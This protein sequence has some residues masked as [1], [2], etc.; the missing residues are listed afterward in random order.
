MI[1][2]TNIPY[3]ARR[4]AHSQVGGFG[5]VWLFLFCFGLVCIGFGLLTCCT[6]Q[7]AVRRSLPGSR[8][9]FGLVWFGLVWFGLVSDY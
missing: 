9:W 8:V 4:D 2:G 1:T 5:L 3:A 6:Q 7:S